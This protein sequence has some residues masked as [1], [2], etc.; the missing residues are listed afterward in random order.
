[1]KKL[2][3]AFLVTVMCLGLTACAG[4]SEESAESE[5]TDAKTEEQAEAIVQMRLGALTGMERQKVTEEYIE[6]SDLQK[7]KF[8]R[9]VNRLLAVN[10]LC[11]AR[12]KDRDDYYYIQSHE[13]LFKNFIVSIF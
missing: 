5:D 11:G 1:M 6:L 10:F 7:D 12:K 9:L 8:S 13:F 4:Q 2:T 3:A